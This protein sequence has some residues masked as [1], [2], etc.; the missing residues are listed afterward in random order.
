MK[1]SRLLLILGV[2]AI[3]LWY[4]YRTL[5]DKR[6][7]KLE[8]SEIFM[9]DEAREQK[10]AEDR[11]KAREDAEAERVRKA[12]DLAQET[13]EAERATAARKLAE[14][15]EAEAKSHV[16]EL[17][18]VQA[19]Q[20]ARERSEQERRVAEAAAARVRMEA[21]R[22]AKQQAIAVALRACGEKAADAEATQKRLLIEQQSYLKFV[23]EISKVAI[24][25]NTLMAFHAQDTASAFRM[26]YARD[27]LKVGD[28][29]TLRNVR[30]SCDAIASA[31]AI[32]TNHEM[33]YALGGI[34][35]VEFKYV[36]A[37]ENLKRSRSDLA[38][39]VDY[40]ADKLEGSVGGEVRRAHVQDLIYRARIWK[41]PQ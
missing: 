20:A 39:V 15:K 26:V 37:I 30:N 23:E 17:E 9:T 38:D 29:E 7:R 32:N 2:A 10:R 16:L 5:E 13:A 11:K 34:E 35:N 18:N 25:P 3:P 8:W 6:V 22:V 21:D 1:F 40:A 41:E 24:P 36:Q 14:T 12:T 28:A 31:G 27:A 4:I 19:G 33:E